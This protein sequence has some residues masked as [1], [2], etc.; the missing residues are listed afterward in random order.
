MWLSLVAGAVAVGIGCLMALAPGASARGLGPFHSFALLTSVSVVLG[1]LLPDALSVLGVSALAVCAAAF[2]LPRA[3]EMARRRFWPGAANSDGHGG[4]RVSHGPCSDVGLE[5]SYAAFLLHRLGDGVGLA[6]FAGP[7]HAGHGHYDVIG[8]IAVHTIPVTALVLTAFRVRRGVR[9]VLVRGGLVFAATMVGAL[10]PLALPLEVWEEISPWLTAA[11]GGLLLHVVSHGW[12]PGGAPSLVNRLIDLSALVAALLLLLFGGGEHGHGHF[13]EPSSHGGEVTEHL[14]AF[15]EIMLD[16]LWN[17]GLQTAP[18]LLLG[19]LSAS[20]I[21]TLSARRVAAPGR[22]GRSGTMALHGALLG[23]PFPICACGVVQVTQSLVRR[24]AVPAFAVAF[25]LSTPGLGV[26]TLLLSGHFLGWELAW[27][28]LLGA[29]LLAIW[30]AWLVSR[31]GV[32]DGLLLRKGSSTAGPADP[33]TAPEPT[34]ERSEG[35]G[36]R[37][38]R[39][40]DGLLYHVGGWTLVGL[41]VAAY[42]HATL[43][44]GALQGAAP[45]IDVLLVAAVAVPSYVCASSAIPLV[46]VLAAKGLSPGAVLAALWLGPAIN[47]GSLTFLRRNYGPRAMAAALLGLVGGVFAL[48]AV[49]NASGVAVAAPVAGGYGVLSYGSGALL[50]LLV[51]RAVWRSGLRGWFA[52]LGEV[53]IQE[54]DTPM[55]PR[56]S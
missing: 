1:Q 36:I 21:Q 7:L 3:M 43:A 5:L 22:R 51:L 56:L 27:V 11:V 37:A 2:F 25:L 42:L 28:R 31:K 18:M 55:P 9:S 47:L 33:S 45:F 38:L 48:A 13:G 14:P 53:L 20:L 26:D 17:L 52:S 29:P 40:F 41:L 54:P 24:G 15:R 32:R 6:L 8:A 23:L 46:A 34:G 10:V 30:A 4:G 35:F 44:E 39:H 19:L 50:L 49:A 12:A 16:A